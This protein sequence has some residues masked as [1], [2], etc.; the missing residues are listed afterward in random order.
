MASDRKKSGAVFWCTVAVFT[1][2]A[3]PLS[4]GPACW[5][6]ERTEQQRGLGYTIGKGHDIIMTV[7]RPILHWAG[8]HSPGSRLVHW[9]ANVGTRGCFSQIYYNVRQNGQWEVDSF[10]WARDY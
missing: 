4:F 3:Y 2:L 8:Q 10:D 6:N 1:F 5:I 9:Y 7:Y